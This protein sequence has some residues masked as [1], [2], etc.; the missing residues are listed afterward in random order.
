MEGGEIVFL[1]RVAP[2]EWLVFVVGGRREK[3]SESLVGEAETRTHETVFIHFIYH[4]DI[5]RLLARR[6]EACTYIIVPE[7]STRKMD[8]TVQYLLYRH[9]QYCIPDIYTRNI[10][11]NE[12]STNTAY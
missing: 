5:Y 11:K 4:L 2:D 6:S 12:L 1:P 8:N 9:T 7:S 3:N 10:S